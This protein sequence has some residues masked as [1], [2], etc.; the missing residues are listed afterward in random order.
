MVT[1]V[2][3]KKI[4]SGN[5][6]EAFSESLNGSD[7]NGQIG[8]HRDIGGNNAVRDIQASESFRGLLT[9]FMPVYKEK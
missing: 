8:L 9:Q 3:D 5:F 7:L 2:A 4:G 6:I 1:L